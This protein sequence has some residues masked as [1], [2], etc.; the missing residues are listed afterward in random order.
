MTEAEK[1]SMQRD[2]EIIVES[3]RHEHEL[4]VQKRDHANAIEIQELRNQEGAG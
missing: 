3:L 1:L 4:E 2:H